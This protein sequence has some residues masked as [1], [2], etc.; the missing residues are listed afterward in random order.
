MPPAGPGGAFDFSALQSALNVRHSF[1]DE[2]LGLIVTKWQECWAGVLL[3][4]RRRRSLCLHHRILQSSKWPSRLLM[5]LLLRTSQNRCRTALALSWVVLPLLPAVH[6]L[7]L[8]VCQV[9]K[10]TVCDRCHQELKS[11]RALLFLTKSIPVQVCSQVCPLVCP[12]V[13]HLACPLVC[14]RACFLPTSIQASTWRRCRTC[15]RTRSLCR[16]RRSWAKQ[17]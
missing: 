17:S 1:K 4:Y 15:S 14:P 11:V 8:Q 6:L 12:L 13:C 2:L 3:N 7:L 16:W 9:H 5:I 10:F